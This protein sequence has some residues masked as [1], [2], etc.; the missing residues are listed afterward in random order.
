M[1]WALGLAKPIRRSLGPVAGRLLYRISQN[2]DHPVSVQGHKLFLA[3][4]NGYPSPDM[5]GDR[6]EVSTTNLFKELLQPGMVF[7][8]VGAHVGFFTLLAAR[9]VGTTGKVY[10]FEP[11]PQ[12]HSLLLKNLD[13]N[14]YSNVVA[15]Q[16]AVSNKSGTTELFLSA[17][18]TGSH[19]IYSEAARGVTGSVVVDTT[20]LD[21]FLE[22]AG[23]P[24]IDLIKI[25]VEGAEISVLDGMSRFL[26]SQH[27]VNLIMEYCPSL[28]ASAGS[29][30]AKMLDRLMDL[31]FE[32]NVI[33]D[34]KGLVPL[35]AANPAALTEELLQNERYRNLYCCRR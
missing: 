14:G 27:S 33:E 17:L 4:R 32:I 10:S 6:Y 19:S 24:Q 23:W 20:T 29:D 21:S 5:V 16:Q 18:D 28:I 35:G 22:E 9:E 34:D 7:V 25:D 13:F 3:P 1:A 26:E 30:P 8:D 12:N 2:S 31:G 11:E 15:M